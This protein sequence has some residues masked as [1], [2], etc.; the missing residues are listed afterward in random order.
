MR[1]GFIG[2]HVMLEDMYYWKACG[3][4][5]HVFHENVLE[6]DMCSRWACLTGLCSYTAVRLGNWCFYFLQ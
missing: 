4:G 3:S 6:E 1:T 5:G 2:S